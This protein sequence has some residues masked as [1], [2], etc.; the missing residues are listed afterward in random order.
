LTVKISGAVCPPSSGAGQPTTA[1]CAINGTSFT[2]AN[3]TATTFQITLPSAVGAS[4]SGTIVASSTVARVATAAAHG[5]STGDS[6]TIANA[7]CTPT[8]CTQYN[9]TATIFNLSPNTFDYTYSASAP[10]PLASNAGITS[11]NNTS[12]AAALLTLMKWVRGQDTQNENGFQVASADTDVRASIHGDVLHA[13]P[14]ILNFAANGATTQ[15]VYA[16]YGGND[17]VFRAVKGGQATTDGVE[18]WAFIPKE[19]FPALK[20]Q[21]DNSPPVLYPS[22]PSGLGATKRTYAWDGPVVSYVERDSTGAVS[23]AYL[24]LSVRR[25]GRF[26]YALDVTTPATP[27]ILWRKGCSTSGTTTTC[28]TGYAELGQTWSTPA[29]ATV[30]A[31]QANGHPVLIF[32]GGY[33]PVSED[34]E[35]PAMTDTMGRAVFVVDAFNGSVVWSA[36]NSA[37]SPTLAVSGMDFSVTADVLALDR[38][39]TGFVDRIYAADIGGNVWRIDTAGTS[40][41][42]WAVHKLAALGNRTSG[43]AGRKFLFGPEAVFGLPGTFDAVVIGSGDR[44]HPLAGNAANNTANRAYMLVDVP[45]VSMR[46]KLPPISA[47]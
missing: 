29:V 34:P 33:D 39:Q 2:V 31:T 19:F 42:G 35:P 32:G 38:H 21:Y 10:L 28:D 36:G 43:A 37:N 46:H 40:T 24:Y 16:F 4:A 15:N 11:T 8:A 20:R 6:V 22:T 44:E 5:Y 30:E 18:Q 17:G 7:T 13:R 47:A 14:V 23:K 26:I 12:S 27:K 3:K 9:A 1:A 25:G 41:S 45:D